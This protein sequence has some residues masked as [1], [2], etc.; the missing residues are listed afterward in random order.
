MTTDSTLSRLA[1]KTQECPCY[2]AMGHKSATSPVCPQC[3]EAGGHW[4]DCSIPG[5]HGSGRVP[6]VPGLLRPCSHENQPLVRW[7]NADETLP[8][9]LQHEHDACF[10]CGGTGSVVV[11]AAEALAVLMLFTHKHHLKLAFDGEMETVEE[12]AE[13]LA[14]AI[15]KALEVPHDNR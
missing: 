14:A 2:E 15:E 1:R 11:S 3:L 7:A 12:L 6:V 4:V 8:E 9:A 13:A 5:C 10:H